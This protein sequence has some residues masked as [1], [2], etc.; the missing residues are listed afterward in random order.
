MKYKIYIHNIYI[1]KYS[2]YNVGGVIRATITGSKV[3]N[4]CKTSCVNDKREKQ[5]ASFIYL[6]GN[7][8]FHSS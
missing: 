7:G 5:E 2:E 8:D 3:L 1:Y 4:R 6:Y